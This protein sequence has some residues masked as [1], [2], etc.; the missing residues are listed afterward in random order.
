MLEPEPPPACENHISNMFSI[1]M[2]PLIKTQYYKAVPLSALL[3]V[4]GAVFSPLYYPKYHR[5]QPEINSIDLATI[6]IVYGYLTYIYT[7]WE[8]NSSFEHVNVS[9]I[10]EY[11]SIG[12]YSLFMV[13]WLYEAIVQFNTHTEKD[14]LIQVG[15]VYM[16][17]A[18]YIYFSTSSLLYY[19]VCIKLAQRAQSIN[20]WIK[21]LKRN[22]PLIKDFY[23]S[24]NVHY[25]AI[26]GF[27]RN[28]NFI[29]LMGFIILTYHIPIDFFNVLFN[30]RYTDIFGI[31]VKS[32]G[33]SWYTYKICYLNDVAD[34]V[35]P[36]LYKHNLYSL[37]EMAA[38]E[39][40]TLYHDL[41]L[42]FYGIKISGPLIVKIG[43][44]TI[45]LIIPTI[46]SLISNHIFGLGDST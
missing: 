22:R 36:Y 43:L 32:L 7:N 19:F 5:Y 16:T 21:T 41:G 15:N 12:F 2:I 42:K 40:Y 23:A 20:D 45:N 11:V 35:V 17:A 1:T 28:W 9:K 44:L 37:E 18:W 26:K 14:A 34:K 3:I 10:N 4:G 39:K 24:Y 13:Y 29:V 8:R 6:T 30:R 25:K 33:L 38:I 31:L 27:G 46:Y